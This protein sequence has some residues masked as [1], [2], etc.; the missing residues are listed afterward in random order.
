MTNTVE[1]KK[2]IRESGIKLN[3]LAKKMGITRTSLSMKINNTSSFK[4]GEMYLLSEII[5]LSDTQAK[6]IFFNAE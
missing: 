6:P 3:Y 4:A 5:G 2:A 1:L